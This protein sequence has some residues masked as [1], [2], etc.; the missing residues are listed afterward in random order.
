[1]A[2]PIVDY[3]VVT[4]TNEDRLVLRVKEL[5]AQGWEPQGGL[6]LTDIKPQNEF[7][8]TWAQAMIKRQ[9]AE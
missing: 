4:A 2:E 8:P 1:M 3:L 7:G 9:N 6:S 5:L